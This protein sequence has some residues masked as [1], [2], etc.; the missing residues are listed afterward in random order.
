MRTPLLASS[1]AALTSTDPPQHWIG[2]ETPGPQNADFCVADSALRRQWRIASSPALKIAVRQTGWHRVS[3]RALIAAG[4]NPAASAND[5][6]LFTAGEPVAIR[7]VGPA[8]D[9]SAIEFF[10]L[11]LDSASTR[12]R[13]YWLTAG[14]MALA[15]VLAARVPEL[16]LRT[17][18]DRIE[19]TRDEREKTSG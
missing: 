14:I 7:V 11:A 17:T 2:W 6:A 13:I 10:G 16:P 5:L 19:A 8:A 1:D 12:Q 9:F 3:R 4:L 15:T 18:H